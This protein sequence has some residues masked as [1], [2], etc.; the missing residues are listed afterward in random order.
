MSRSRLI[1]LLAFGLVV[2]GLLPAGCHRPTPSQAG[3]SQV[4][5][6]EATLVMLS[7]ARA[8]HRRADLHLSDGDVA[9]AIAATKEV[10]AIPFPPDA[11]EAE[12]VRL[13]ACARLARLYLGAGGEEAEERALAQIE[14]G[15]KLSSH[16][17]FFRAHLE[18]VAADIYEGRANRLTDPE[19]KKAEKRKAIEALDRA[20]QIDRRV[21]RALLS[22]PFDT[23]KAPGQGEYR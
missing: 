6:S 15:R 10:L 17:S 22:L 23:L 3:S 1:S 18:T 14:A 20:I 11:A 2:G 16:D 5:S 4:M 9:A 21:Q 13:D 8:W 12:E 19:A 7:E